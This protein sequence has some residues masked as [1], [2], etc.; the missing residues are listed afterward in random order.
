M[1]INRNT[2]K[3]LLLLYAAN[4][5]GQQHPDEVK[6]ILKST[7]EEDYEKQMKEFEKLGDAEI[8]D[9]IRDNKEKYAATPVDRME[10]L[11]DIRSVIEADKKLTSIEEY[12]YR[13]IEKLLDA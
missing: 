12:L 2:F 5:D 6:V 3:T 13:K 10:L 7:Q 4:I 8:L 1:N 9:I 11:Y